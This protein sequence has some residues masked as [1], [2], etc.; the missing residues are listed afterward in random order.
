[1]LDMLDKLD[2][3]DKL[4]YEARL[5]ATDVLESTEVRVHT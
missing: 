5:G 1:V 3:L 4:D 2:K